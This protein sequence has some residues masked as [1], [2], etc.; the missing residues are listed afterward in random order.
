MRLSLRLQEILNIIQPV[1]V[2]ADI[3]SDH[4][5]LIAAAFKAGKCQR[6][7]VTD[8]N[9]KPLLRAQE[10]LL[11]A[12]YASKTQF[13][14]SDGMRQ[15]AK[16]AN[17]WIIAG[18]GAML[19]QKIISDS[20][21]KAK[22]VEQ[23]IVC[24]HHQPELLRQYMAERG[25]ELLEETLVLDGHYYWILKYKYNGHKKTLS[26]KEQYFGNLENPLVH[27]YVLEQYKKH[28]P[29]QALNEKSKTIIETITRE[30]SQVLLQ[31]AE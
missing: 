5:K 29:Y 15:V 10:T 7:I 26:L 27:Q 4:G 3:G 30:F 19:I 23:L 6:A 22:Q 24:P 12:G 1:E 16:N 11:K 31:E 28:S 9:P 2:L 18:M 21:D 17:A 20:M 8:I 25:F 14:E 13:Y